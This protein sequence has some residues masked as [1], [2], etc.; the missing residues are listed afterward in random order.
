MAIDVETY[1]AAKSYTDNHGGG[2]GGGT[3][4]YNLLDN[5]PQVNNVTLKGNK[6][7]KDLGIVNMVATYNPET[8]TVI[9]GEEGGEDN[10][11]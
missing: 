3:T 7:L 9:L 1:A 10:G 2:G 5:L 8:E 11:N 6:S 4:N